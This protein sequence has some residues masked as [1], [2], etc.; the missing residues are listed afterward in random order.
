M[1]F[2]AHSA[3]AAPLYTCPRGR[4]H[5]TPGPRQGMRTRPEVLTAR[6]LY[7]P[8]SRAWQA[9]VE[10]VQVHAEGS[11]ELRH[12]RTSLIEPPLPLSLS[13]IELRK[14]WRLTI[15]EKQHGLHNVSLATAGHICLAH[16]EGSRL[17]NGTLSE[18]NAIFGTIPISHNILQPI[19]PHRRD[20]VAFLYPQTPRVGQGRGKKKDKPP[21]YLNSSLRGEAG[22]RTHR[23]RKSRAP[24]RGQSRSSDDYALSFM[25]ATR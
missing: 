24:D 9:T 21:S 20:L 22:K 14:A 7:L 3:C 6:N 19:I 18:Q 12:R 8:A 5:S 16:A 10:L 23:S 1:G 2:A 13:C 17:T 25:R 4:L 15:D 11:A